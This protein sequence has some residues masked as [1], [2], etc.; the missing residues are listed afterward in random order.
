[1]PSFSFGR[2]HKKGMSIVEL[3]VVMAFFLILSGTITVNLLG[4]QQ[5]TTLSSSLTTLIN[6]IKSQQLK[7]QTG[8]AQGGTSDGNFGIYFESTK[9]TLFNGSVYNQSDPS[10]LVINLGEN[11]TF[12]NISFPLGSLVFIKG[13]GEIS[14]F[15]PG[16]DTIVIRNTA[17]NEQNT[18]M[19]NRYG[20]I[21][22]VN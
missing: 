12:P 1:M 8:D 15:T 11:I 22:S 4:L 9:Y 7:A 3:V 19:L 13:S 10:N 21:T 5:R 2:N 18:I 20:V 6:D 14:G 16:S 17:S